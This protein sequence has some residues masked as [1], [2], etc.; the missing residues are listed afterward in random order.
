MP[1]NSPL[2]IRRP[3]VEELACDGIAHPGYVIRIRAPKQMGKS[4]LLSRVITHAKAQAYET[5]YIDLREADGIVFT[6]FDRFLRWFCANVGR[7]LNLN[8]RL[9]EYWDEDMGS[10]VSCKIYF[11]NYLLEQIHRPLLLAINEVDRIFEHPDIAQDFLPM[12]RFWHEQ[13][14]QVEIWQKL[15]LVLVH[16]TE[17]YV[18]LKLNQ[19]PFNVGLSIRLPPFT[20]EQVQDLA[21]RYRLD[22]AIGEE[23]A[24]CLIPLVKMV[25]GHPYLVNVAL[26]HLWQQEM[27]IDDL[28]GSAPTQ[29]GIYG[30][31]LR[32][33]LGWLRD[34][35]NLALALKRVVV[36]EGGVNLEA[37][38][39]YKLESLG[40]VQLDG[41]QAKPSCELYRLYFRQQLVD[42]IGF[43][44]PVLELDES[45]LQLS[46]NIDELTQLVNRRHFNGFL[47]ASWQRWAEELLELALILCDIDYFK[48]YNDAHGNLAGDICIQRIATAIQD[49]V[50]HQAPIVGRYSGTQFAIILLHTDATAAVEIAE[51][52]RMSVKALGM[53]HDQ[54]KFGGFPDQVVTLSLGIASIVPNSQSAS[55]MLISAA[56]EALSQSKREGRDRVVLSS[57]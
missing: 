21:Q 40:L 8:S 50:K 46:E 16:S 56:E 5:V 28:L 57:V 2:Y 48:F 53:T 36:A 3:P 25:G 37:I 43:D 6:S 29:A 44:N 27:T 19:S 4:S 41:N 31:H 26:Y 9:D 15:R 22:W 18:P 42:G 35:P 12:L 33:L 38:A 20:L 52:I 54:T 23:G 14:K 24:N 51:R 10:K 39:A 11:E 17:I 30:H 32:T 49:C 47:D 13:A 55:E 7:Q 34:E 45:K 1:L